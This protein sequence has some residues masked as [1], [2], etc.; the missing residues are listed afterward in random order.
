MNTLIDVL[1]RLIE[2]VLW[3]EE[4]DRV[5]AHQV[6]DGELLGAQPAPPTPPEAPAGTES[7]TGTEPSKSGK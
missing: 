2:L 7:G 1:H 4:A 5:R 6:V 3:R